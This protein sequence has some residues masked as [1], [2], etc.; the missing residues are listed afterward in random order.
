[1]DMLKNCSNDNTW[2]SF[3]YGIV[4]CATMQSSLIRY[5]VDKSKHFVPQKVYYT[6]VG[7]YTFSTFVY[8]FMTYQLNKVSTSFDS[9]LQY[10]IKY[11]SQ[12]QSSDIKSSSVSKSSTMTRP[13]PRQELTSEF[14]SSRFYEKIDEKLDSEKK[15]E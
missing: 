2:I 12:K 6:F 5:A 11:L 3:F 14:I 7:L 8:M 4:A 13:K 15:E 10:S 1:M 9:W